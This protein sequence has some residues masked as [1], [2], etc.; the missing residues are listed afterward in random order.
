MKVPLVYVVLVLASPGTRQ[1]GTRAA[2]QPVNGIV[3]FMPR[4]RC[5]EKVYSLKPSDESLSRNAGND[6]EYST[7]F[8]WS[9]AAL[10]WWCVPQGGRA[11][12]C[13]FAQMAEDSRKNQLVMG[14][15]AL[16]EQSKWTAHLLPVQGGKGNVINSKPK[17]MPL[18]SW[19]LHGQ[20]ICAAHL[21]QVAAASFHVLTGHL[22]SEDWIKQCHTSTAAH[23]IRWLWCKWYRKPLLSIVSWCA[24]KVRSVEM[25]FNCGNFVG[26]KWT[27]FGGLPREEMQENLMRDTRHES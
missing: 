2:A 23:S 6:D 9:T 4:M 20:G 15:L 1:A 14:L 3:R 21:E 17:P 13:P 8:L 18:F 16:S 10:V 27:W 19:W 22:S 26:V 11:V 25:G 7:A 12:L 24:G 5:W